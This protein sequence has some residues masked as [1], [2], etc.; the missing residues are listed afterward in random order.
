MNNH[1][2]SD[3]FDMT[4]Q[5]EGLENSR[6]GYTPEHT[7]VISRLEQKIIEMQEQLSHARGPNVLLTESI[8]T[9]KPH[10]TLTSLPLSSYHISYPQSTPKHIP[11]QN[12]QHPHSSQYQQNTFN[13]TYLAP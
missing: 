13:K 11:S 10:A 8:T 6:E 4:T 3:M 5:K 9:V 7:E 1:I 12:N 2:I